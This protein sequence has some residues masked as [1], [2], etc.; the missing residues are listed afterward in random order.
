MSLATVGAV[1]NTFGF[2]TIAKT[3]HVTGAFLLGAAAFLKY[4]QMERKVEISAQVIMR[5]QNQIDQ[6]N[7]DVS[8]ISTKILQLDTRTL[9]NE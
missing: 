6:L 4:K 2:T 3:C 9:P 8:A 7:R 5:Q 1:A